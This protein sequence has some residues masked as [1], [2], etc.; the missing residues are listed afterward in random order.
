MCAYRCIP[1]GYRADFVTG[2][3]FNNQKI[4]LQDT[5]PCVPESIVGLPCSGAVYSWHLP[6]TQTQTLGNCN[7]R[8]HM[9]TYF[10]GIG[11]SLFLYICEYICQYNVLSRAPRSLGY[12]QRTSRDWTKSV[13]KTISWDLIFMVV[14]ERN[15]SKYVAAYCSTARCG[16]CRCSL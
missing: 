3:Y 13:L 8:L 10:R 2:L 11:E 1:R 5:G 12:V 14:K 9:H 16:S 6:P 15:L 4:V 7:R